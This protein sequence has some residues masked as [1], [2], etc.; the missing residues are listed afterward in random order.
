MGSLYLPSNS[1]EITEGTLASILRQYL[2]L[3]VS[4][5]LVCGESGVLEA[6]VLLK[7]SHEPPRQLSSLGHCLSEHFH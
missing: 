2:L 7:L 4:L 5:I 3:L 6:T 1:M